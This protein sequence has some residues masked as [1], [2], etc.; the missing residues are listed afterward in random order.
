M[1][2]TDEKKKKNFCRQALEPILDLLRLITMDAKIALSIQAIY[3]FQFN[4]EL[5]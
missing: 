1:R 3:F 4:L 5:S 2:M